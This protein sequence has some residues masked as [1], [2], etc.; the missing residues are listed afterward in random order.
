MF[1]VQLLLNIEIGLFGFKKACLTGDALPTDA[2]RGCG[3][4]SY[5]KNLYIYI[6]I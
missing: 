1:Q 6:Y 3:S 5:K 2:I 4:K